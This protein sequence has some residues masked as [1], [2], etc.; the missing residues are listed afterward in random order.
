VTDVTTN[1]LT[2]SRESRPA[3]S[4]VTVGAAEQRHRVLWD[5]RE[6]TEDF[7]RFR[8]L[9][10]Q[11]TLRD[12]RIRYKQ[13]VMGFGWA[14]FMPMLII[15]AGMLLR[16]AMATMSG[17]GLDRS[18]IAGLA[19]KSLPW[20]FFVG[21]LGFAVAS[22][23]GNMT[24]V[25]KVYFPREVLPVSSVLAQL[26]DTSI[27]ALGLLIVL[28]AFHITP[29]LSWL[30]V[31]VLVLLLVTL[32]AGTCL[33]L[34]CGNLFFRDVKYIVQV[35]LTFGIFF[36]PVLFEPAMVGPTASKIVMLNPLAPILEG[37]RLAVVEHHN[38]LEPLLATS[39]KGVTF[40][41]WYPWYLGYTAAW[42]I[43]GLFG[44]ALLFHRLE[45]VFAEYI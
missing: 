42:A 40:V 35:L 28:L 5:L 9:L 44:S 37:L 18:A 36:T 30:W 38:L 6:V 39:R 20:A 10:Y 2:E 41:V 21:S 26:F 29:S 24:L 32:T 43:G 15:F 8:E 7:W 23:T 3:A 16:L 25:T 12:I 33:L 34:S 31:P 27:G 22:L 14:I 4:N 45:F 19:V 11:L 13:A 1:A 17:G